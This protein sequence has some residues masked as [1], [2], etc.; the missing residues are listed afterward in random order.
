MRSFVMMHRF[1]I[2]LAW[3]V[4]ACHGRRTQAPIRR[5]PAK[6]LAEIQKTTN[7]VD[8][9][10]N[11]QSFAE[12]AEMQPDRGVS[13]NGGPRALGPLTGLLFAGGGVTGVSALQT[14]P[15]RITSRYASSIPV[16]QE[17]KPAKTSSAASSGY[18]SSRIR[19]F[20]IIAHIDHGK[21][22]LADRL[23]QYTETVED[24][25]MKAQL[26]DSMDLERER[27]I[28]IKL[29]AAR[30]SYR[31]KDGNVYVLNLIDTPGHVDF[32][33]EVSRS[34]QA[35][36]GALLVVDA[37]QGVEAQTIANVYLAME[38][39][40][41]IIPVLNKIDLPAAE[42]E[43]V[44]EEVEGTIGIDCT[45]AIKSS[46]KAGIGIEEILEAIVQKVPPP[47]DTVD[48]P[49]RALIFDSYFDAFRG[50][51]TFIRL[52]DG[53]L[54]KGDKV[55]FIASGEEHTV[56]EVGTLAPGKEKPCDVLRAG[57]VGYMTGA[58][59]QIADARVGDTIINAA[60]AE[61]GL[62]QPL[63]GYAEPVPV[64]FA[65]LFP[66]DTKDYN[67]LRDALEKLQLNDAS[68]I[69][70]PESSDAMGLGFRCGF[71][72]MLHM[73]IVQERLE[74]DNGLSLIMSTPSV[75]YKMILNDDSVQDVVS[76]HKLP[77]DTSQ[78]KEVQEPYVALEL[79][80]RKDDTG[81]L[82]ELCQK[83]RGVFD[84]MTYI[85]EQRVSLKYEIPM[86]EVITDFFDQVKSLSQGYASME[87]TPI[88]FRQS[89]LVK[90]DILIN[91]EIAQPMAVIVHRASSQK[92][93]KA[94]CRKLKELIPRQQFK[95]PIQASLGGKPI[96][97]AFISPI[98]K[99]VLAKCYGGDI[100]RKKKLLQKQAKG[101]KKLKEFGKVSVPQEAFR[102]ALNLGDEV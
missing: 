71:L 2:S 90:M 9:L 4:T 68:L 66:V 99:D 43:R 16:M 61:P 17:V 45:D 89:D 65:G 79:Y 25:D 31:A 82:M 5:D 81:K 97:S 87:Y 100:S 78:R 74:R 22:T 32:Q 59:K 13:S 48:K 102:A 35:C 53:E 50:V 62:M 3:L 55:H 1:I 36:E 18:D 27:G 92:I 83:R 73:E 70:E 63:P 33:Y 26:L 93:G 75:R 58:I 11:S 96:A 28:T 77:Q 49:L 10:L 95:V 47:V 21:S 24:R 67:A 98:R 88:G 29:Q 57:E 23:L 60:Q 46:A 56:S 42:P 80:C 38:S 76:P 6:L 30:M 101:K 12:E 86:A 8:T 14:Q 37:A 19:N 41:E 85:T 34:L 91:G 72:G 7:F 94:L 64:V 20:C 15:S 40:L 54:R 51:I 44:A 69:F 52:V 84:Q 39:N